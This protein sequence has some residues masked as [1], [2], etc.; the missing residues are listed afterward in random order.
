MKTL[1]V[2]ANGLDARML[3]DLLAQEGVHATIRSVPRGGPGSAGP[4]HLMVHE[5]DYAAGLALL[6][7]WAGS[8]PGT[9]PAGDV[10]D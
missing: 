4:V 10:P 1:H 8:P 5:K 9:P 7:R 3:R 6:A 2:L